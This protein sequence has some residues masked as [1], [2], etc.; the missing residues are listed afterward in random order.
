MQWG[1]K[2]ELAENYKKIGVYMSAHELLK[3]IGY[4]EDAIRCL[5]MAGRSG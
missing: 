5:F 1:I 3:L 4:T 2:A